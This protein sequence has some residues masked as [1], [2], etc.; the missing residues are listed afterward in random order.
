MC[1]QPE[2][3][4]FDRMSSY[5]HGHGSAMQCEILC[6][7]KSVNRQYSPLAAEKRHEL[8]IRC[9][10]V[11]IV[12]LARDFPVAQCAKCSSLNPESQCCLLVL[13]HTVGSA[14]PWGPATA[15]NFFSE[16][17]A[18][19]CHENLEWKTQRKTDSHSGV[20]CDRTT[21]IFLQTHQSFQEEEHE[22]PS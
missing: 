21:T 9:T 19:T 13:A 18:M 10:Q 16:Y 7:A 1:Q 17:E 15:L 12:Q 20:L 4:S 22:Y 6:R 11:S 8:P 14:P 5:G 3:M 2:G